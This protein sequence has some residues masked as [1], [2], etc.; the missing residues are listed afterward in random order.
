M[1]IKEDFPTLLRPMKAISGLS[2]FGHASTEGL[3]VKYFDSFINIS[4]G[5]ESAK[6][7]IEFELVSTQKKLLMGPKKHFQKQPNQSG[8]KQSNH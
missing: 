7:Q 1:L 2:G 3:L 5:A 8:N 4:S 6:M